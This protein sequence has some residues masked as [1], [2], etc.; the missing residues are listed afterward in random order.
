MR[1][2]PQVHQI[3]PPAMLAAQ[4]QLGAGQVRAQRLI[5]RIEVQCLGQPAVLEVGALRAMVRNLCA[6]V[7]AFDPEDGSIQVEFRGITLFVHLQSE[8]I[9]ANGCDI[10]ALLSPQDRMAVICLSEEAQRELAIEEAQRA[11]DDAA[12]DWLAERAA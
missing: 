8:Q 7:A 11:R 12:A 4:R 1:G 3:T 9:Q 6:E 5:D 2:T 10:A